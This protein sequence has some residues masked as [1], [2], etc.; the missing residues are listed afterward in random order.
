MDRFKGDVIRCLRHLEDMTARHIRDARDGVRRAEALPAR[1]E[2]DQYQGHQK[3]LA[4]IAGHVG[5]LAWLDE[6]RRLLTAW[7]IALVDPMAPHG[8]SDHMDA[9]G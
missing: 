4:R 5:D 2:F 6:T 9:E 3:L 8:P 7:L 1:P